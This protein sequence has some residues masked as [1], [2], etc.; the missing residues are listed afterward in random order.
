MACVQG[1]RIFAQ[2]VGLLLGVF[3]VLVLY[4]ARLLCLSL[5]TVVVDFIAQENFRAVD[6][7]A[8]DKGVVSRLNVGPARVDVAATAQCCVVSQNLIIHGSVWTLGRE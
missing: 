1:G 2:V 7:P 5:W 3:A 8:L 6:F 4:F